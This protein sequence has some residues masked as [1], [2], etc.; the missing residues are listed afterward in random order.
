MVNSCGSHSNGTVS[1]GCLTF[2]NITER[3]PT[4]V[5]SVDSVR[6]KLPAAEDVICLGLSIVLAPVVELQTNFAE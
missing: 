6:L 2:L 5:K 4:C 1:N 3:F